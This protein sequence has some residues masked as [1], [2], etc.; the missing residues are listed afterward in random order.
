VVVDGSR[1]D[2]RLQDVLGVGQLVR[3]EGQWADPNVG[4]GQLDQ[5]V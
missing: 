2:G 4:I 3:K 5:R 1:R